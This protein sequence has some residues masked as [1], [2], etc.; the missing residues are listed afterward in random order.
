MIIP[1]TQNRIRLSSD[2]APIRFHCASKPFQ[3][4]LPGGFRNYVHVGVNFL[5]WHV[6][7]SYEAEL[8][9]Q[10]VLAPAAFQRPLDT[11]TIHEIH[12]WSFP[13]PLGVGGMGEAFL[14]LIV[15][16]IIWF[17]FVIFKD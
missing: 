14:D 16:L 7:S 8:W 12:P 2:C 4:I 5:V 15:L 11:P 6:I 9:S 17:I 10:R 1:P 13:I 3:K